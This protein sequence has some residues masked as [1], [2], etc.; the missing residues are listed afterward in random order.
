MLSTVDLAVAELVADAANYDGNRAI[1]VAG[2]AL[3]LWG[4]HYGIEYDDSSVNPLA[5]KDV[6]FFEGRRDKIERYIEAIRS[7]L[8]SAGF[9]IKDTHWARWSDS[10]PEVAKLIL[11]APD[12]SEFVV[13]FLGHVAGL[14][15]KQINRKSIP[16]ETETTVSGCFILSSA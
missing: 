7:K 15:D 3:A 4:E 14:T 2:Q 12:Q 5:S 9:S 16:I 8:A 11:V 1:L 6:D 13:D 10:T